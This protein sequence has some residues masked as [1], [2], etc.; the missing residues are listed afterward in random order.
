M[1]SVTPI[2]STGDSPQEPRVAQTVG[3]ATPRPLTFAGLVFANIWG[4]KGRSAGIAAA[5]A[6]AVMTVV[7]LTVVSSGLE[8]SASAVLTVGKANFT[9]AQNGVSD[10]LFSS[11]DEGQLAQVKTTKGVK[12]AVGVLLETEKI[13]AANPLFIEIGIAPSE[14]KPFG[15][16]IVAGSS[17][18]PTASH[19]VLLGWR[20]AQN[21][22]LHVGDQFHAN[23][24][25]NT[26]VGIYST[27]ISYGDSGAMFPLPALQ[28]YNRVP[29]SVSLVFVKIAPGY[30][31]AT[32]ERTLTHQHP[33]LTTISTLAQ[34]GRADRNL[35]FLRAMV[36]GSTILAIVIGAVIVGNTMLLSLFERTREFGLLR[37]IGWNRRRVVGLVVTEG[38]ALALVGSFVA[39]G[40]SFAVTTVLESLPQLHGVL[41]SNFT[42]GAFMRGLIV[43]LGMA[44]LGSLYPAV[45]AANLSP[46]K[47]LSDE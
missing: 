24:T 4:K 46:L 47:A 34:A 13:N 37:A 5:V 25:S 41:H 21:L 8:S 17:Y 22:G 38:L 3:A 10:I 14:L 6:L 12:S 44:I 43:G 9:V 15:V 32:V 29:G 18:L 28:A 27:G 26:V 2:R 20:A 31:A 33:E 35:V 45:R 36:T 16:T 7:T 40:L 19:A 1:T 30:K 23:G 42:A 39:V 11:I